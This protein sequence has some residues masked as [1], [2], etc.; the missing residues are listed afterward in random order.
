MATKKSLADLVEKLYS[1]PSSILSAPKKAFNYVCH[2][3]DHLYNGCDNFYRSFSE[4]LVGGADLASL[5]L[6]DVQSNH[7]RHKSVGTE[8]LKCFHERVADEN[9]STVVSYLGYSLGLAV[10]VGIYAAGCLAFGPVF[11]LTSLAFYTAGKLYY[12]F[13]GDFQNNEEQ[14]SEAQQQEHLHHH[15]H[16]H[17]HIAGA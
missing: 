1:I 6:D 14:Q 10:P 2:I 9:K 8:Y 17:R 11:L 13:K 5:V 12:L 3:G 4:G 15:Y 16:P 7:I